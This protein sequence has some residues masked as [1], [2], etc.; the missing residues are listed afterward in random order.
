MKI[1]RDKFYRTRGGKKARVLCT[2]AA[3]MQPVIVQFEGESYTRH[4]CSDG[5]YL[6]AN[7]M[8]TVDLVAPWED[9]P[10]IDR[11]LLPAWANKAVAMD[12]DGRWFCFA[13]IPRQLTHQWVI[14]CPHEWLKIP[15]SHAPKW[16]G[17][18]KDS[19]IVFED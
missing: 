5:R 16:T 6:D 19:L 12:E 14:A 3:G 18:W 13:Q 4:Y 2:D 15:P 10:F 9:K 1:E 7:T 11:S 8:T 17:N